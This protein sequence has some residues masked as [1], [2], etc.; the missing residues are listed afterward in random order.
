[1]RT[2]KL[3]R[4]LAVKL[5][6]LG[7]LLLTEPALRSLSTAYPDSRIDVLTTPGSEAL[8]ALL[9]G[10]FKG[11]TFEKQPFDEVSGFLRGRMPIDL[12]R[13]GVSLRRAGYDAVA[14]FHHLTTPA[15][16]LKFRALARA[17]SSPIV[18]G[19][20]NGRGEFLT[21]RTIDLGFGH[22]HEVE[23]MLAVSRAMGGASVDASPRLKENDARTAGRNGDVSAPFVA[24]FPVTGP[25][26]PGRNWPVESFASLATNLAEAGLQPLILGAGDASQ[27]ASR[28]LSAEP[29]AVD[30]TGRTNLSELCSLVADAQV[31]ITGDSFPGHLAQAVGTPVVSIF[32][33]SNHRAWMPYGASGAD[34]GESGT[35]VVVRSDVPC[36]PCLYTGYR[37]GRRNGCPVRSCLMRVSVEDVLTAVHQVTRSRP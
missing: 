7:D 4:I 19:L 10:E 21:H 11:V 26:A 37:L 28:I 12:A 8:L 18:A 13:I 33:P 24:I 15:G 32:G 36:S 17:T 16:A 27:A 35:A 20:D 29:R 34:S 5:A 14:I 22:H 31:A 3:D 6:D 1:M 2:M 9:P 25:F 30:M 23:Y